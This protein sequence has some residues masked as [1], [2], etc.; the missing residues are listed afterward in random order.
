[1]ATSLNQELYLS[2]TRCC[3]DDAWEKNSGAGVAVSVEVISGKW[4]G[5]PLVS[6][7]LLPS[8]SNCVLDAAWS[9]MGN[10]N[11]ELLKF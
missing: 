10:I 8:L 2:R 5:L 7:N 9:Y 6:C 11:T 1:M 3:A 4:Q